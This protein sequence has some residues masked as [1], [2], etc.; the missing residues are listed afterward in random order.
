MK[1]NILLSIL[2]LSSFA[3]LTF[4]APPSK[5][6]VGQKAP[7]L[8]GQKAQGAGLMKLRSLLKEFGFKKDANGKFIEKDGKYIPAVSSNV[9]VLNFFSTTCV[10]CMREIPT[11]NRIAHSFKDKAVKLIYVNIDTEVSDQELVRFI[12][13]KKIKLPMMLP[14]QRDAIKKYQV[15]SLPRIIVIGKDGVIAHE[16]KGFHD[17]LEANM[18]EWITTLLAS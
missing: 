2:A 7:F 11:Y 8:S 1:K 4:A 16:V 18:T 5:S 9:V 17:D 6:M 15:Y 10:P 3:T 14:N 12:A 13:K